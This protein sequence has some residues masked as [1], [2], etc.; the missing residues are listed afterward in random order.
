[1]KKIK[2]FTIIELLVA[3]TIAGIVVSFSILLF[4]QFQKYIY[5]FSGKLNY[6]NEILLFTNVLRFDFDKAEKIGNDGTAIIV[7]LTGDVINY[8]FSEE[9]ILRQS[10]ERTDTFHV[11]CSDPEFKWIDKAN[12]IVR[13]VYFE[14]HVDKHDYY[15]VK[16]NKL[17]PRQFLFEQD[18]K[19]RI[20]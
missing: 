8:E 14:V 11:V 10:I 16:L 6:N 17:Y 15:P 7:R 1:M 9:Y 13:S 2:A 4:L 20:K 5:T 18:L 12:E 3:M 19:N